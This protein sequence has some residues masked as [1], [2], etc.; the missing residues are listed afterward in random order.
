MVV[1]VVEEEVAVVAV[2]VEVEVAV[3]AAVVEEEVAVVVELNTMILNTTIIRVVVI[4]T[5]FA[6]NSEHRVCFLGLQQCHAI[7]H[8]TLHIT[9]HASRLKF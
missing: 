9:H 3:V 4:R 8:H 1:V 5:Q 2:V 7:T 6:A